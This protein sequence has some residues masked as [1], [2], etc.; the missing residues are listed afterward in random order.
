MK[1]SQLSTDQIC[2]HFHQANS[3]NI[4]YSWLGNPQITL[5][6]NGMVFNE[7]L[8]DLEEKTIRVIQEKNL[9][10]TPEKLIEIA[11]LA[12]RCSELQKLS[13]AEIKK[14]HCI[15]QIFYHVKTWIA[16]LF[17]KLTMFPTHDNSINMFMNCYIS[18]PLNLAS[19]NHFTTRFPMTKTDSTT[20]EPQYTP[21]QAVNIY[22]QLHP[23]V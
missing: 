10:D 13:Q 8:S 21:A 17:D 14:A 23:R 2:A 11:Y 22:G 9:V 5:H 12:N 19:Q 6:A 1:L 3:L 16:R 15:S 4:S 7:S 20:G 18:M